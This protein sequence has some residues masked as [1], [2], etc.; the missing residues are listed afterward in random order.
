MRRRSLRGS[1]TLTLSLVAVLLVSCDAS[2]LEAGVETAVD[3]FMA[4]HLVAGAG[5]TLIQR[6]GLIE[7]SHG[8]NGSSGD[9]A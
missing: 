4:D 5:V 2:S 9:P 6:G 1:K 8:V 7:V 3:R